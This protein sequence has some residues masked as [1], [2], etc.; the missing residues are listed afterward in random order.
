MITCNNCGGLGNQM[1]IIF[2]ALCYSIKHNIKLWLLNI[3]VY[4]SNTDRYPYW[5]T[6]FSELKPIVIDDVPETIKNTPYF[7]YNEPHFHHKEI[8]HIEHENIILYGYFQSYKYFEE[9]FFEIYNLLKLEQK[10]EA[11]IRKFRRFF[12]IENIEE[13]FQNSIS[14]H[15]RKG[16]YRAYPNIHPLTPDIY[17]FRSFDYII[18][19]INNREVNIQKINVLYFHENNNINDIIEVN[20]VIKHLEKTYNNTNFINITNFF[21]DWEQLLLMSCCHHNIIPNSSFGW[22]GAY[23]NMHIDK[24]I[25]YPDVWFGIACSHQTNDLCPDSWVVIQTVS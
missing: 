14:L 3:P 6:I 23:L 22:W 19:E 17:Y 13:F 20:N 24:I 18:N 1:F 21:R 2:N 10:K 15:F 16:D 12:K 7:E 4:R 8:P 25:T 5:D 11:V 9:K